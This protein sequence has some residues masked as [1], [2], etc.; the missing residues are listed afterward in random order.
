MTLMD[1][2]PTANVETQNWLAAE[3]LMSEPS[4]PD[5]EVAVTGDAE[6][7]DQATSLDEALDAEDA[8][9]ESGGLRAG[10]RRRGSAARG[11]AG[12]KG[13]STQRDVFAS[14]RSELAQGRPN[15][16]IEML[17][18]ELGRERSPRG[19]FVRETQIAFVMV[20][21]GL[22]TVARPILEKLVTT[23]DERKLEDW[24]AGP[25]V[26]QPMGL[27]CRVV[28]RLDGS[29]AADPQNSLYL[30]VCRLDPM[31]AIALQRPAS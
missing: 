24:E 4:A 18:A 19:R 22:D 2:T 7:D 5:A 31:Q 23:I 9:S 13:T 1:D 17:L 28:A 27:L 26:A 8:T 29:D 15:R 12:T 16:A 30:R 3:A 6:I 20:A 10:T 25:L 14:A 21:A 11:S